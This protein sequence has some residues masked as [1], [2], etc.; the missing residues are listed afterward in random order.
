MLA[1]VYVMSIKVSVGSGGLVVVDVHG[2]VGLVACFLVKNG[3]EDR[4]RGG[5]DGEASVG[6]RVD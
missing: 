6:C 5:V 2:L 4:V 3:G 1:V